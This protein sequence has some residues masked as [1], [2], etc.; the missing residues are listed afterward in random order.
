MPNHHTSK[1]SCHVTFQVQGEHFKMMD[2]VHKQFGVTKTKQMEYLFSHL[3]NYLAPENS[4]KD[5][6]EEY[7]ELM[8]DMIEEE[9]ANKLADFQ[10]RK[11]FK[12][13]ASEIKK[14]LSKHC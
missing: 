2:Y 4:D 1:N 5:Y 6:S 3:L 10:K 11:P 7:I 9:L 13:T 14:E 12:G 8:G